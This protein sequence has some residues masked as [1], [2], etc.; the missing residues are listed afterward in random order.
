MQMP[1]S[2]AV[3][4][5][6]RNGLAVILA[7]TLL[8]GCV[9][10]PSDFRQPQVTVRS[11]ALRVVNGL[12]IDFDIVLN[13]ANPNR[14]ALSAKGL[15]YSIRLLGRQVVEGVANDIPTI[16]AYGE[17]EVNLSATTDLI[18]GLGLLNEMLA[19]PSAP[20]DYEFNAEIDLGV[21]YP[22]LKVQRS[23]AIALGG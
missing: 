14:T 11:V 6:A 19:R 15:T 17:A 13:V 16:A 1:M 20:L 3:S 9:S 12:S 8:F 21:L 10:L 5:G 7:A 4:S 22:T 2:R 23:G 18:T